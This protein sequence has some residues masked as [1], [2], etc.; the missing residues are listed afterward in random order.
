M[1]V[2]T[3]SN[4]TP[5]AGASET[6]MNAVTVSLV[7]SSS[8]TSQSITALYRRIA[9]DASQVAIASLTSATGRPVIVAIVSWESWASRS[10]SSRIW[11]TRETLRRARAPGAAEPLH[12]RVELTGRVGR[13]AEPRR[14]RQVLPHGER[15]ARH[16][17]DAVVERRREEVGRAGAVG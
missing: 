14:G 11:R 13:E 7:G 12:G 10:S 4:P 16:V 9:P 1:R 6:S 2:A 3:S 15:R 8:T 5:R 17:P